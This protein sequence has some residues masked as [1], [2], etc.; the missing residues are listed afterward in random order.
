MTIEFWSFV[1]NNQ[2]IYQQLH[3]ITASIMVII[4]INKEAKY[5]TQ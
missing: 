3:K 4:K 5:L 1:K 2:K